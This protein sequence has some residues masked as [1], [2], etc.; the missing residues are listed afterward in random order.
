MPIHPSD[1]PWMS[2]ALALARRAEGHTS[3]NPV[4]GAVVVDKGTLVGRGH[5]RGP[6]RPHAEI[7]ALK[8]AG[9]RARGAT[10][11]VTLEP[12]C[13][14]EKRTPPCVP[15]II[16][17]QVA[18]AVV[19]MA[20]PNPAVAGRG[21]AAL[22][23]H[24]ITVDVGCLEEAC[25]RLNA[26][27]VRAMISG[28]PW[29]TLKVAQTLDGKVATAGGESKWITS[30]AARRHGHRLRDRHDVIL[31]G[32]GT[33]LADDPALTCRVRGGRHPVR[34]VVDPQ[35]RTPPDARVLTEPAAA[36]TILFTLEG[37]DQERARRLEQA[38]ARL[39]RVPLEQG[40][41]DLAQGLRMLV[42]EGWHRVLCEGGPTLSA[43][44][45]QQGLVNGVAW[46]LAPRVMG[47]QDALGGVGGQSPRLLSESVRLG[48]MRVRRLGGDLLIEADVEP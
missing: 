2:R 33:V 12:C 4:V 20:D 19:G 16:R 47:G 9:A 39:V 36:P 11:F 8:Q 43:E 21:V 15:E 1:E 24:G 7:E 30:E 29:L 23:E 17:S 28:L 37:A 22:R 44:L 31:V 26:P 42:Q 5:H 32:I 40:R 6:G 27:Y 18:R 48:P 14:T 38:G 25:R 46:Y 41:M 13:H 34:A 35:L 3:P 45:L 10:L